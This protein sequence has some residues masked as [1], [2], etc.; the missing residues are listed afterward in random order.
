MANWLERARREIPRSTDRT[1]ANSD[2]R[3]L[4][5][6]PAVPQPGESGFS[7]PSIGSNGGAPVACLQEIEETDI[8]AWLAYID[9]TNPDEIADVLD[10]CHT[11]TEARS[12]F[13][14]RSEEV[15]RPDIIDDDRR[16]CTQCANLTTRGLC[17]AAKRGD[18]AGILPIAEI[19]SQ[20]PPM[21]SRSR[22]GHGECI[23]HAL[24]DLV[25][26]GSAVFLHYQGFFLS[27]ASASHRIA[28]G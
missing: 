15:P 21:Q 27:L 19:C 7:G 25:H 17:L 26:N 28:S 24:I 10:K 13:L 20:I 16:H 23:N 5:A 12:Y 4:T 9:E 14:R 11:N 22:A 18:P 8:R 1:T 2:E 3:T 6:V